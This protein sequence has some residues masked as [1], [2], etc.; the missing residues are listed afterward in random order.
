MLSWL[1]LIEM[2][3]VISKKSLKTAIK[4]EDGSVVHEIKDALDVWKRHF[5]KQGTLIFL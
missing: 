5:G 1:K 3:L 4:N 2:I